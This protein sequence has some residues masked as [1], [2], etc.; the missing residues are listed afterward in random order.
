MRH[1]LQQPL[2]LFILALLFTLIAGEPPDPVLPHRPFSRPHPIYRPA[3][4]LR[5]AK[6]EKCLLQTILVHTR[7]TRQSRTQKMPD[8]L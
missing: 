6:H 3:R 1:H 5:L 8:P 4:L 2:I 7:K